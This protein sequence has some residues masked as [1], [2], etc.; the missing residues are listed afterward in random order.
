MSQP[1]LERTL[2]TLRP[3]APPELR[4]RVRLLAAQPARPRSFDR[5]RRPVAIAVPLAAALAA[6]LVAV[7]TTDHGSKQPPSPAA[8]S[9]PLAASRAAGPSMA[10]R[11][12]AAGAERAVVAAARTLGGTVVSRRELAHTVELRL[13]FAA[14]EVQAAKRKL[15]SLPGTLSVETAPQSG[16]VVVRVSRP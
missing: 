1:D 7:F 6:A 10:D 15:A 4:E 16:I 11:T 13:R 3:V 2:R 12:E 14:S 9:A 8:K 5:W